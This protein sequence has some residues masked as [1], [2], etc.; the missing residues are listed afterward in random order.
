MTGFQVY[1]NTVRQ[2]GIRMTEE[3]KIVGIITARGGSK[4]IPR[5]NI[6]MFNKK[7]LI[8]HTIEASLK[9]EYITETIVSSDDDE[10]LMISKD[11]GAGIVKRLAEL[12]SDTASSES[13]IEDTIEQLKNR[14]QNFDILVLLQPTSP[15]RDNIDI[16]SALAMFLKSNATAMISVYEPK[17]SPYKSFK[18]NKGNFMEGIVNNKFPFARRQDL[19]RVFMPNGALYITYVNEFLRT[20]SLLTDKTIPYVMSTEKSVDIDSLEDI[21]KNGCLI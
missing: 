1:L 17:H 6:V 9:S 4:G 19:P 18:L 3:P 12:A 13:V 20:K 11:S 5:K 21:K 8:I 14:G 16:D 7:P 15:L 2:L 10:I